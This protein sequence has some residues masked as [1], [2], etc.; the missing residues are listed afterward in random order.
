MPGRYRPK[1]LSELD[2]REIPRVRLA[3]DEVAGRLLQLARVA[4]PA[5]EDDDAV[6][7]GA[8]DLRPDEV[9]VVADRG[10][11]ALAHPGQD[12]GQ[13]FRVGLDLPHAHDHAL[14]FAPRPARSTVAREGTDAACARSKC[15]PSRRARRSRRWR[16][17]E[18]MRS[19]IFAGAL[20]AAVV[21]GGCAREPADGGP[22]ASEALPITMENTASAAAFT[23]KVGGGI[24]FDYEPT[25][26]PEAARD[27]ADLI[28]L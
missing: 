13:A 23:G 1:A 7:E 14:I 19:R 5:G 9:R 15:R 18:P 26:S 4:P 21:L 27:A 17:V 10:H 22:P 6:V 11:G 12:V 8:E 3:G 24:A 28:V 2:G 25:A 20:M 16:K